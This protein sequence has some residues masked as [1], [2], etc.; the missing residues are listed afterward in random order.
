MNTAI[1]L[2]SHG[3]SSSSSPN[4]ASSAPLTPSLASLSCSSFLC[5]RPFEVSGDATPA[6]Y[7]NCQISILRCLVTRKLGLHIVDALLSLTT[8]QQ[9]FAFTKSPPQNNDDW[10]NSRLSNSSSSPFERLF[11]ACLIWSN[12]LQKTNH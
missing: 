3:R 8:S 12:G 10:F 9:I 1:D 5:F 11:S 6:T 2:A 7:L 4:L